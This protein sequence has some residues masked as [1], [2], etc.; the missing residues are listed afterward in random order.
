MQ[1]P[2]CS[3][4]RDHRSDDDEDDDDAA[5]GGDT[6]AARLVMVSSRSTQCA[7]PDTVGIIKKL[8]LYL[9]AREGS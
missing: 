1:L 3:R 4:R 7:M 9:G 8:T 6:V 2:N 5:G